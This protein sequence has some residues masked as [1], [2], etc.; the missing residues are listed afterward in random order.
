MS[1]ERRKVRIGSVVRDKMDKTVVVQV[2]WRRRHPL[3]GKAVRRQTL[4]RA[5]DRDNQCRIGDTVRVMETRPLSKTKRWRVVEILTRQ[6]IADVLP[7]EIGADES[8]LTAVPA[9]QPEPQVA[10]EPPA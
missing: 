2:E 9:A 1:F 6:D 3:Y 8:V 5:H 7:E 4:L 10:E